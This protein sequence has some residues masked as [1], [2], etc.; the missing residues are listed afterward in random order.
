M[1][2]IIFIVSGIF[3]I[4]TNLQI[5]GCNQPS[6]LYVFDKRCEPTWWTR[7]SLVS[8]SETDPYE[9]DQE[10]TN[11]I[12]VVFCIIFLQICRF[13]QRKEAF[14]CDV[15]LV[16]VSDY[17]IEVTGF[18]V[19]TK[20]SEIRDFFLG[21]ESLINMNLHII[22]INRS[23]FISDFVEST[24][25]MED[26][27]RQ[28]TSLELHI[29][30][31]ENELLE[32]KKFEAYRKKLL[33]VEAQIE[34]LYEQ[35]KEEKK[36]FKEKCRFTGT[37]FIT[38]ETPEEART[39][40]RLF[41]ISF[42]NTILIYLK[43]SVN[44]ENKL[45][46]K[47]C[48]LH[49]RRAPEPDD[50]L[51]ENLGVSW[52]VKLKKRLITTLATLAILCMSFCLILLISYFQF[53]IQKNNLA[54]GLELMFVNSFGATLI[55]FVN[56]TLNFSI[57]KFTRS[58]KHS[59]LTNYN[60]ALTEKKI[61]AVFFNTA[62]IYILIS[63]YFLNF[64][65]KNGLVENLKYIYL[66]NMII[67]IILQFFDPFYLLRLW[68]RRNLEKAPEK[69]GYTQSEANA[70]YEGPTQNIPFLFSSVV[71][72]ILFT[73]FYG[74]LVPFGAILGMITLVSWYWTYKYLL[75]RRSSVPNLLG[76]AMAYEMIEYAE[77]APFLF[78][79]GDI[80][81]V[82]IFYEEVKITN[83]IALALS[84]INFIT[85]MKLINK[86]L[87]KISEKLDFYKK[88]EEY[89]KKY[90]EVRREIPLEF[91]RCNPVTKRKATEEWVNFIE[92][93]DTGVRKEKDDENEI[94]L[95]EIEDEIL[96]NQLEM[97]KKEANF[98]G[99]KKI[100]GSLIRSKRESE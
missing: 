58:E 31:S 96:K 83:L 19:E 22:D 56:Y 68:N 59:T 69:S 84:C 95:G 45:L 77:F 14:K 10:V 67:T 5:D 87:L 6:Y 16:T 27:I 43:K 35:L 76:K 8:K 100:I 13:Y 74:S 75:L 66:S 20:L 90:Q 41:E 98:K 36:L 32:K 49:I 3:N 37:V 79:L 9:T 28:K 78:A 61:V 82:E 34:I 65:G 2:L 33:Q 44:M 62:I 23:F 50:V 60:S 86:R 54:Q 40:K 63:V 51:W 52:E 99:I 73:S 47:D 25:K 39:V 24:R 72:M 89:K 26:L 94:D 17:S 93:R 1:Q 38:F 48:F 70:L 29:S 18:P 15:K 7:I 21:L 12:T 64:A 46:F 81:F 42:W 97:G 88:N 53:F 85:P 55:V 80:I 92:N 57:E 71:N 91:D 11:L 4:I 30:L